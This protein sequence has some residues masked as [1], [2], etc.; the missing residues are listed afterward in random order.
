MDNYTEQA[1]DDHYLQAMMIVLAHTL[2][3]AAGFD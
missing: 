1:D 2:A 3:A